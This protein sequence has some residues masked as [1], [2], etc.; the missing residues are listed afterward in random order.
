MSPYQLTRNETWVLATL[1]NLPIQQGSVLGEWLALDDV[2]SVEQI[3]MWL[4]VCIEEIK[5]KGYCSDQKSISPDLVKSLMLAAIGQKHIYTSIRSEKISASTRFL[6]AGSGAVQYGYKKDQLILHQTRQFSEILPELLPDWL[7]IAVEEVG[8]VTMSQNAFLLFKEACFQSNM[9]FLLNA[10]SDEGFAITDLEN[11]FKR[12]N[13]WL[14]IFEALRLKGIDALNDISI[15]DQIEQLIAMGYLERVGSDRLRIG[16]SGTVLSNIY[17]DPNQVTITFSF[18]SVEPEK[19][20]SSAFLI[21]DERIFRI[22]F[23]GGE[24][25]ILGIR[26]RADALNWIKAIVYQ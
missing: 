14:D 4:P 26:S 11:G 21:G 2:P 20:T 8:N 10:T 1:L 5:N 24:L 23:L 12:D 17:S 25:K 3:Q 18:S 6:L 7:R 22:D 19:T 16:A 15:S 13:E 9:A